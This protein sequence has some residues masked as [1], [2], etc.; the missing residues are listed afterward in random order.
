MAIVFRPLTTTTVT[1]NPTLT[2]KEKSLNG[3][4]INGTKY[5]VVTKEYVDESVANVD[6]DLT[7]Y[8]TE[9]YVNEAVENVNVDLTGYATESYVNEA[10]ENVNVD[11]T[12][13]ATESYVNEAVENVNVDLTGYA[14]EDYV[15]DQII[16]DNTAKT[17]VAVGGIAKGTSLEGLDVKEVIESIFFPYVAF[18]MG[19]MST[20]PSAGGVYEKGTSVTLNSIT[21]PITL[22]SKQLTNVTLYDTDGTTVLGEKTSGITT[23]NT[24]SNL[25]KSISGKVTFKATATDGTTSLSKTVSV[26]TFVDPYFYGALDQGYELN[27]DTVTGGTKQVVSKGN[28]AYSF[29]TNAQHPYIAYPSSY[30]DLKSI[31]DGN[32]FEN[33]DSF[34]KYTVNIEVASGTVSYN[35]YVQNNAPTLDAFSYTFKY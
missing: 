24:F 29:T 20:S 27:T 33:I 31:L 35:V 16:I 23:S 8:A 13:Y 7:G 22:G 5:K 34:T 11:L 2:G 6:V 32:N 30:G 15:E 12:G 17:T 1:A 26:Y 18:S 9:S 3:I 21:V 19:N 28:K 14:T 25:A 10:V 4:D